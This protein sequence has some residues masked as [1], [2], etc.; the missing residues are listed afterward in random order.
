M[1]RGLWRE[2]TA[3]PGPRKM[4]RC[5]VGPESLLELSGLGSGFGIRLCWVGGADPLAR[6]KPKVLTTR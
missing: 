5:T 6:K 3:R 4:M 2:V 1:G